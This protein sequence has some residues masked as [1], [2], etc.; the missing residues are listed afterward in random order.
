MTIHLRQICLVAEQLAPV[1]DGITDVLGINSCYIDP[2]V[3]H[4]GLENT[5]MAIGTNFIEVVAPVEEKT[6]AGR[7]LQRRGGD[8]GYM[9]ICQVDQH[10]VQEDCRARAA[11]AGVRVAWESPGDTFHV[12]QLH[13][14]DLKA[15]FFEISWDDAEDFT[16]KWTPAGRLGWQPHVKTDVTL[17]F[18]GVE[19]QSDDPESLANLWSGIAGYPVEYGSGEFSMGLDNA[20]IRFVE[21]T[22]GRGPGLA[23]IDIRVADR[24][25]VLGRARA[26]GAYRSDEM[27]EL[28]GTRFYLS[29]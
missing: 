12:M 22:D 11:E 9:V 6:A 25:A 20:R 26:T 29:D 7:Y 24:A 18:T 10:S 27:I 3:A 28:C 2:G 13:P 21:A 23:G 17:E 4:F 1:I 19:L 14:G 5:L 16:G 15:A 8:G